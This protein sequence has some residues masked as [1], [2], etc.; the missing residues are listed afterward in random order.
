M[1]APALFNLGNSEFT[2][3]NYEEAIDSFRE[4]AD[5]A[6]QNGNRLSAKCQINAGNAL[7]MCGRFEEA[8]EAYVQGSLEEEGVKSYSQNLEAVKRLIE[9]RQAFEEEWSVQPIQRNGK[10][11]VIAPKDV[12]P[13]SESTF[14]FKGNIGNKGSFGGNRLLGGE[15]LPGHQGFEL[16]V[17]TED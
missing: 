3:G 11:L 14:S 16:T 6:S 15:G 10:L 9:M 1:R 12:Q 17:V 5:L 13:I 2:L 4:A 8:C 7:V